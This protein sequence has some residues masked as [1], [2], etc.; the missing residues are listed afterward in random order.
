[1]SKQSEAKERQGYEKKASPNFCSNCKN[2]SSLGSGWNETAMRCEIGEFKVMRQGICNL[3]E[4]K[5]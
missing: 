1:M 5:L 4:R 3:H 2:Y